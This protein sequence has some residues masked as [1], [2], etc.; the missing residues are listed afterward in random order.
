M[1]LTNAPP[2]KTVLPERT[3]PQK[4]NGVNLLAYF[5]VTVVLGVL[6]TLFADEIW[7]GV[8]YVAFYLCMAGGLED[9]KSMAYRTADSICPV[10]THWF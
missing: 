7:S 1:A 6:V 9:P 8:A 5:T 10:I 3:T 2:P 4:R